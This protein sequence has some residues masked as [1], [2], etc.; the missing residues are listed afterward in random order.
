MA[1][2]LRV[3]PKAIAARSAAG[4]TV[5]DFAHARRANCTIRQLAHAE[6]SRA[7]STL[8]AWVAPVAVARDSIFGRTT[9]A[10]NA[11][12]IT[13]VHAGDVG[14]FGAGAGGDATAVAILSDLAAIARDRAAIV[15][16]PRLSSDFTLQTSNFKLQTSLA[17]AV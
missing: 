3:E 16:P 13:G 2:G 7:T 8:T 5:A 9:G 15:P 11:A 14:V 1:F 12:L 4:V 6:Y 10:Q 17:E